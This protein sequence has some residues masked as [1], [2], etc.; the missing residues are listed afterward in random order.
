MVNDSCEM[1]SRG[2]GKPKAAAWLLL[3]PRQTLLFI[4]WVKAFL[5]GKA[6]ALTETNKLIEIVFST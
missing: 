2:F 1:S 5:W 3:A 6:N 4:W